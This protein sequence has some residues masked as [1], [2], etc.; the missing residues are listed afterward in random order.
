M[1]AFTKN[2]T[3]YNTEVIHS[4]NTV[5]REASKA[6]LVQ[7][8]VAK[9]DLLEVVHSLLAHLAFCCRTAIARRAHHADP[10]VSRRLFSICLPKTRAKHYQRGSFKAKFCR[11]S[12]ISRRFPTLV[13]SLLWTARARMAS[14]S[15]L[16]NKSL[17]NELS[18]TAPQRVSID[19]DRIARALH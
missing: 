11:A 16:F 13:I 2:A 3:I 5:A 9:G 7:S 8:S 1:V 19:P 12:Q 10:K 18:R 14:I 17:L 15:V 4:E 6:A